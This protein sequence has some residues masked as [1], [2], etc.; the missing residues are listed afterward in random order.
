MLISWGN[1]LICKIVG[2]FWISVTES[3]GLILRYI[4]LKMQRLWCS[5]LT[6]VF[7]GCDKRLHFTLL[8]TKNMITD[9]RFKHLKFATFALG[10]QIARR[11]VCAAKLGLDIKH[12]NLSSENQ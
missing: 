10:E 1:M 11:L 8:F 9:L 3:Y 6:K 4:W 12:G 7:N 2:Y 5:L